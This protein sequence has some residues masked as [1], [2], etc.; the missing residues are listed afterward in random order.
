MKSRL[1]DETP[2]PHHTNI[3]RY[4]A[5]AF[6]VLAITLL[7]ISAYSY[8]AARKVQENYNDMVSDA[9]YRLE[10]INKLHNNEDLIYNATVRHLQTTDTTT[11]ASLEKQIKQIDAAIRA[12]MAT[13][14]ELIYVPSRK[15]LVQNYIDNRQQYTSIIDQIILLSRQKKNGE[16]Q[17]LENRKLFPAFKLHQLYLN[18]LG[19]TI[20]VNTRKRGTEALHTIDSTIRNYNLLL[21]AALLVT[22]VAAYFV[23]KVLQQVR[24]HNAILDSEIRE[25][26]QLKSALSESQSIYRSLFRN[27][28]I[29]MWVFDTDTLHILEVNEAALQEYGY[30]RDE[31][32]NLTISDLQPEEQKSLLKDIL[33]H[34][35]ANFSFSDNWKHLRKDGSTFY[36]DIKSHGL[37]AQGDIQPRVVVAINI[38][39]RVE[40]IRKLEHREKQLIEVSS[41]IPGAVYQ[42][43]LDEQM[44]F[45]FPFVSEGILD[46][47]NISPEEIKADANVIFRTV[48]PDDVK[49]LW[50]SILDSYHNMIPWELEFRAWH[51]EQQKYKWLRGHS[52][53]SRKFNG[54]VIWNGTLIDITSQK[55]V[56]EKLLASEANLRYLLNSSPQAIY[57]LDSQLKIIAFNTKAA[58]EVKALQLKTLRSGESILSF[59][60]LD[61]V[62]ST[63][64]SHKK[65]FEGETTVFETNNAGIWHEVA[66]RPVFGQEHQVLAVALSIEDITEQK[67]NLESIKHS[68]MQLARA[69]ELSHV[70]SWE[71][72]IYKERITWSDNLYKIYGVTPDT[73][74]PTPA[75]VYQLVHPDDKAMVSE[76]YAQARITGEPV[77]LE[78][79][80][81]TPTGEERQV[82][83]IG[84]V[85]KDEQ[86]KVFRLSGTIQDITERKI[87]EQEITETKNLLQSILENIP[88]IVFS[89]DSD[90]NVTY[91]SPQ[92]Y[93]MLGFTASEFIGNIANWSKFVYPQD[94]HRVEEA[95]RGLF[96]GKKAQYEV[97]IFDSKHKVKWLFVSL[98]ATLDANGQLIRMDGAAADV[99]Q[100]KVAEAKREELNAQLINQ[101]NNLQ[102]FA[103]I[104]SHN[105][106]APIA[107]ILGLTS[108]YDKN[109]PDAPINKRVIDNMFKSARLLDSTIRDLNELL[110]LRSELQDVKEKVYFSDVLQHIVATLSEE[111]K[112]ADA[113]IESDF[114]QAPAIVTIKSYVQSI[115]LNL[116]SNA[117]KYRDNSR[118][119]HLKLKSFVIDEYICLQIS[120]TG[121]GIDIQ[122][123]K[124]R[125]FGLYKRFHPGIAGKGLGLY[126]VKTQAELLGGKVEVD[127]SVGVGTTF[128]VY[129]LKSNIVNEHIKES[130]FN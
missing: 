129:F 77:E 34:I 29:P 98:S 40:A 57:L 8:L 80:V 62:N 71:Y 54:I 7:V 120:D 114:D 26:K 39:A 74:K 4:T 113:T 47:F 12:D 14:K 18:K 33:S 99:T 19:D 25:R 104:V 24:Y 38:D 101:N 46:L 11:M 16:A 94:L 64:A 28:A 27:I 49:I 61:Q 90:L 9:L 42:F 115:L 15:V 63:I 107:N 6:A 70:G 23:R 5:I 122:K 52:L 79:R 123:E 35:D 108:I 82:I 17:L 36:V 13:L 86:G 106:R 10:L 119:L 112:E 73:F 116:I 126:L 121:L 2:V 53:P 96:E 84:E 92:C 130:N 56:Q 51:E 111:I 91:I 124:D 31:F 65:A 20:S 117:L 44:R 110:T 118:K 48:H 66:F 67:L 50:D 127:S 93:E 88:E 105:L 85:F 59:V 100:L 103:Y 72:D 128:S 22:V 125:I 3:T 81:I 87:S 76:A 37:P 97:R 95:L 41:S 21:L 60:T 75:S 43:Q 89:M 109:K 45:T 58:D 102:Q 69:Q 68:Q 32:L 55:E 78:H 83:Q 30:T 1:A